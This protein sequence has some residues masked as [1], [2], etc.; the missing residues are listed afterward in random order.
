MKKIIYFLVL[1]LLLVSCTNVDKIK[2][3]YPGT[4][5][6]SGDSIEGRIDVFPVDIGHVKMDVYPQITSSNYYKVDDAAI[7]GE[8]PYITINWENS[9]STVSFINGYIRKNPEGTFTFETD[10]IISGVPG[11]FINSLYH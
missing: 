6:Q 9:G 10:Y 4:F 1:C 2:G 8:W 5:I 3:F 11:H 7:D